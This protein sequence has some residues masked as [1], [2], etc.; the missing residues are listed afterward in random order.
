M[1][2]E[3]E[4]EERAFEALL[5]S[6]MRKIDFEDVDI[7]RIADASEKERAALELSELTNGR[8]PRSAA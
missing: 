4:R 1:S 7:D 6:S 2:D 3:S 5:V 8:H